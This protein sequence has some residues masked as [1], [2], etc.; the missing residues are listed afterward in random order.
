MKKEKKIKISIWNKDKYFPAGVYKFKNPNIWYPVI[1]FRKPK[2]IKQE[3]YD[4]MIEIFKNC[5]SKKSN[6]TK[7]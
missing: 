3:E 6:F 1:Y 5:C 2:N 4:E 7:N